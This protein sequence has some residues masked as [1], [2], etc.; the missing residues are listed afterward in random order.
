[1]QG[2]YWKLTR[3]AR[4]LVLWKL[5]GGWKVLQQLKGGWR[6]LAE[7]PIFRG[8][9]NWWLCQKQPSEPSDWPVL[10]ATTASDLPVLCR[11]CTGAY[12][13]RQIDTKYS[14]RSYTAIR[15]DGG[16]LWVGLFAK[17]YQVTRNYVDLP[18][19]KCALLFLWFP[20]VAAAFLCSSITFLYR[21]ELLR[22]ST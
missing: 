19:I 18:P 2:V 9:V 6:V 5:K 1:M 14:W 15:D 13:T 22:H 11:F 7:A 4:Y 20:V 12:N 8:G 16:T 17:H 3:A 21:S 10:Y